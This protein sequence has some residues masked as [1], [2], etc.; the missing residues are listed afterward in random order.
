MTNDNPERPER[1]RLAAEFERLAEGLRSGSVTLHNA[2]N[3]IA[4]AYANK[5]P[6]ARSIEW[7]DFA[8]KPIPFERRPAPAKVRA[9]WAM[10]WA[11]VALTHADGDKEIRRAL[12]RIGEIL[13]LNDLERHAE[14]LKA[15]A[16]QVKPRY[17]SDPVFARWMLAWL[18]MV[19]AA[20]MLD[21]SS[22][23]FAERVK[24]KVGAIRK[25]E[26]RWAHKQRDI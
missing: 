3:A 22:R 16:L 26:R 24:G 9:V 12:S 1:A 5:S 21:P 25:A 11:W 13:N 2:R 4:S 19:K 15:W 23:R 7:E 6:S 8:D 18:E 14:D 17:A 20:P 10:Q